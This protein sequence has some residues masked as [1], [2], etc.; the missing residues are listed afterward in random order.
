MITS[1][2]NECIKRIASLKEKK[3]RREQGAYLVEGIKQVREALAGGLPVEQVVVLAEFLIEGR[4]LDVRLIVDLPD[5]LLQ[6][7]PIHGVLPADARQKRVHIRPTVGVQFDP[8]DLRLMPQ[9]Q[10]HIFADPCEIRS[11]LFHADS[12]LDSLHS[13]YRAALQRAGSRSCHILLHAK[14]FTGFFLNFILSYSPADEK[15]LNSEFP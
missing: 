5:D 11:C 12:P 6:N 15:R 2:N 7:I 3:G 10:A 14:H 1:K 9:D 13:F 8:D 4:F